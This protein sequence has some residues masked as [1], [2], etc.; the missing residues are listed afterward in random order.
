MPTWNF[1]SQNYK[2]NRKIHEELDSKTIMNKILSIFLNVTDKYGHGINGATITIGDLTISSSKDQILIKNYPKEEATI[3]V[4]K[5]GYKSISTDLILD[6]LRQGHEFILELE[7]S[8]E[9]SKVES[10]PNSNVVFYDFESYADAEGTTQWGTGT[11][12]TTGIKENGYIEIKVLANEPDQSFVNRKFYVL[13]SAESDDN[14]LYELFTNTEGTSAGIY[15]KILTHDDNPVI[16]NVL[17]NFE[18]FGD[19]E[20]TTSWGEGTVKT[21]GN[22]SN[23]YI[24]VEVVTNEPDSSFIGQKFYVSEEATADDNKIYELFAD[25]NGTSSGIYV[26]IST[27]QESEPEPE[28]PEEEPKLIRPRGKF[29]MKVTVNGNALTS[30]TISEVAED[31]TIFSYNLNENGEINNILYPQVQN[32]IILYNNQISNAGMFSTSNSFWSE[33]PTMAETFSEFAFIYDTETDKYT[34]LKWNK[35][36]HIPG[37]EDLTLPELTNVNRDSLVLIYDINDGSGSADCTV[38]LAWK[39]KISIPGAQSGQLSSVTG[40][41]INP[42]TGELD[43][44]YIYEPDSNGYIEAFVPVEYSEI[45]ITASNV[46]QPKTVSIFAASAVI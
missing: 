26:T 4:E 32:S 11:V 27:Y 31:S 2:I 25:T 28:E 29:H 41:L 30:G 46:S 15:V 22:K 33:Y 19:V 24:E 14:N 37:K 12:K 17:Y 9:D 39:M 42:N 3:T 34:T 38:S 6:A 7:D 8:E 10:W 1:E 36:S 35:N 5:E 21:T 44:E 43:T 16:P 20:G 23:G 18:S 45:S 13:E 40:T